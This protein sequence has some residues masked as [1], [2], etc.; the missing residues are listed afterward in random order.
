MRPTL[1]EIRR[2][3]A[4]PMARRGVVRAGV[5]GSFARGEATDSSDVDFLVEFEEGRTLLDL[6]GLRLDLCDVLGREV[7]VATPG[8]L[9]PGLR[10]RVLRE[11]VSIL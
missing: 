3:V 8:S 11:V 2:S 6:S 7:D 1:D 4:A 5:F 9:H 10:E